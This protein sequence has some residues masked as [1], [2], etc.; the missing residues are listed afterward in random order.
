ME[1]TTHEDHETPRAAEVNEVSLLPLSDGRITDEDFDD[2]N[3]KI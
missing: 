1:I 3:D 2:E